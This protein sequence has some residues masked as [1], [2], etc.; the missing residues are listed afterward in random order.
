MIYINDNKCFK[1][2][3]VKYLHS[4]DLNSA[5][6]IKVDKNTTREIAFKDM[7]FPVKIGDIHKIE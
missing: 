4:T 7:T 2:C 3:L 6:I 5:R 1:C